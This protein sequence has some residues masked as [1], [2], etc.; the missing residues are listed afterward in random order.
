MLKNNQ[1]HLFTSPLADASALTH[2]VATPSTAYDLVYIQSSGGLILQNAQQRRRLSIP[3]LPEARL[4]FSRDG[5]LALLSHPTQRYAHGVLGD[6]IEAAGLTIIDLQQRQKP[7][8]VPISDEKV[9]EGLA[10]ILAD[11]DGDG[12]SEIVVTESDE[13]QGARLVIYRANGDMMAQGPPIGQGFRWRHQLAVGPF[14][15]Q[16]EMEIV[17]VQTPHIGGIVEFFQ[18]DGSMLRSVASVYGMQRVEMS[19]TGDF[20]PLAGSGYGSHIIGSRNLDM[21]LAGDLDADG[22]LEVLVPNQARTHLTAIRRSQNGAHAIWAVP[23]GGHLSSNLAAV[24]LPGTGIIV[25]AG[26]DGGKLRLWL[27]Q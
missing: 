22:R 25:A 14:G 5:L 7:R 1:V 13:V 16:G 17:S 10:P 3:A 20:A 12:V 11:V 9:I 2:P 6:T 18:L 21:G 8:V 26:H 4:V 23:I 24:N 27:P 19:A 15:P